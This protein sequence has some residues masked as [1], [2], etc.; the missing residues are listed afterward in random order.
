MIFRHIFPIFSLMFF[1][2]L[3]LLRRQNK[4][5]QSTQRCSFAWDRKILQDRAQ[6]VLRAP[7]LPSFCRASN[8]VLTKWERSTKAVQMSGKRSGLI[9]QPRVFLPLNSD[10]DHHPN[11]DLR[12]S[13]A[14]RKLDIRIDS[15]TQNGVIFRE[16]N[17][18]IVSFLLDRSEGAQL[19]CKPEDLFE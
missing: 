18:E 11:A 2:C 14:A 15:L 1:R 10:P 7:N 9:Q 13:C 3:F 6:P 16:S 17:F 4:T 12:M 5:F 8:K 19:E